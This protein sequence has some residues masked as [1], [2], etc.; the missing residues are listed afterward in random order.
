MQLARDNTV[1]VA[2]PV[3][4]PDEAAAAQTLASLGPRVETAS[5]SRLGGLLR[6]VV[7]AATGRTASVGYFRSP[8]LARRIKRLS[9]EGAFDLIVVHSSSVAPY[10]CNLT[11]CA[12]VLDFVDMDS[13]KWVDYTAYARFPMRL[14]YALEGRCLARLERKLAQRFD[15]NVTATA[16]ES[17]TLAAIAGD[18]PR[19]V[20]PNGV[21][22]DYF[23]PSEGAYDP[24]LACFVGRMDYFPNVHAM[25]RF[26][27]ETWPIVRRAVPSARLQIVGANP[28]PKVRALAELPGVQV[29]GTVDDVRPYVLAA[30][31]TVAPLEI[32]RGTQNKLLES[33][34]LGVPV[35]ASA[36]AARGVDAHTPE[37]LLVADGPDATAQRVVGI[38]RDPTERARLSAAGRARV[39]SRHAWGRALD[40]FEREVAAVV[41][42][43][44]ASDNS[45]EQAC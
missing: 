24:M 42:A 1:T 12:K 16:F 11:G 35:I 26:C 39:E 10:V 27:W 13:R 14:V 21:D 15:L 34:A 17:D 7:S 23:Q 36:L 25:T 3:R 43:T 8:D 40:G 6:T 41:Q 5:I 37:H 30:A 19:A 9:T 29:T 38:M 33:M 44:A 28:T 32:A 45:G 22:L 20:V 31:C 2:A 4:D 18:V